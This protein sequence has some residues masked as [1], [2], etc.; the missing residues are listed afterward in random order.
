MQEKNKKNYEKKQRKSFL[1]YFFTIEVMRAIIIF[2]EKEKYSEDYE[3][4]LLYKQSLS[5]EDFQRIKDET[6][7]FFFEKYSDLINNRYNLLKHILSLGVTFEGKLDYEEADSFYVEVPPQ[8]Y[9]DE[10]IKEK[11]IPQ[12]LNSF[13]P[14]I[15][16]N[17]SDY[18]FATY[19]YNYFRHAV[20]DLASSW[21]K[22][23][24]ASDSMKN[25]LSFEEKI[26]NEVEA[27]RIREK[28]FEL[29]KELD[30]VELQIFGFLLEGKKQKDMLLINEETGKP[31]SKGYISKLVKKVRAKM[32]KKLEEE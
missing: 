15:I 23:A 24:N 7:D 26:I 3:K 21:G 19:M 25:P 16:T 22:D 31:Y 20:R 6:V 2:M 32:K 14:E 1:K 8:E 30:I 27:K 5:S 11:Y 17:K 10:K 12:A 4:L 29:R 28:V 13:K 18:C 9:F